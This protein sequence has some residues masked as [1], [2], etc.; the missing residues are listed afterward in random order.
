[1]KESLIDP[2]LLFAQP[3]QYC[4]S[5][6]PVSISWAEDEYLRHQVAVS[7]LYKSQDRS[8][9]VQRPETGI[10]QPQAP[11]AGNMPHAYHHFNHQTAYPQLPPLQHQPM[12]PPLRQVHGYTSTATSANMAYNEL[13]K[14]QKNKQTL[15]R[16]QQA[17]QHTQ[18][19]SP[20]NTPRLYTTNPPSTHH[21]QHHFSPPIPPQPQ[22]TRNQTSYNT[23]QPHTTTPST[24]HPTIQQHQQHY[25]PPYS[26]PYTG[27]YPNPTPTQF[28]STTATPSEHANTTATT[29]TMNQPFNQSFAGHPGYA[30][31]TSS[32]PPP[33]I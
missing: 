7:K 18:T 2:R 24:L 27:P 21:Q 12:L 5:N 17:L 23:L 6:T 25:S 1:M 28:P 4:H 30:N 22:H 11:P 15:P 31:V 19:Q 20:Y 9:W 14:E 3:G 26:S 16:L 33:R 13:V 10:P 32:F 8:Y 29:T